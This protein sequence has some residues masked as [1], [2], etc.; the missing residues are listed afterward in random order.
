MN[1][2]TIAKPDC[3]PLCQEIIRLGGVAADAAAGRMVGT[4]CWCCH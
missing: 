2:S 1:N 3:Q 4:M